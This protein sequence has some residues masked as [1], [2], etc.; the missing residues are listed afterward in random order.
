MATEVSLNR[1]EIAKKVQTLEESGGSRSP[2]SLN[3]LEISKRVQKLEESGGG[4]G[5]ISTEEKLIDPVNGIYRQSYYSEL[6]IDS[7][8][9]DADEYPD[10][11]FN[12]SCMATVERY[13]TEAG[14]DGYKAFNSDIKGKCTKL[15]E[16]EALTTPFAAQ[17]VSIADCSK[18][19]AVLVNLKFHSTQN[20]VRECWCLGIKGELSCAFNEAQSNQAYGCYRTFTMNEDGVTFGAGSGTGSAASNP[21]DAIPTAVYGLPYV[22]EISDL[23]IIQPLK[24]MMATRDMKEFIVTLDYKKYPVTTKKRRSK[25]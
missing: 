5:G 6:T 25:K 21:T 24:D 19:P 4:G 20:S 11:T 3:I 13:N 10:T 12:A 1:L 7:D 8:Y 2:L 23:G 9:Y 22:A 17:K 14:I 18:Y 16:N 15:W